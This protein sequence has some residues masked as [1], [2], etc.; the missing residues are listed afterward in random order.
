MDI[1]PTEGRRKTRRIGSAEQFRI[2]YD[3]PVDIKFMD[4]QQ[5][6]AGKGSRERGWLVVVNGG[7]STK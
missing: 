5:P 7:I 3:R 1:Q 4:R 6:H 2:C